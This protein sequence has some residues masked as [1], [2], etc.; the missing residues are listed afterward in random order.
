M[1]TILRRS[2]VKCSEQFQESAIPTGVQRSAFFR[3]FEGVKVWLEVYSTDGYEV[4]FKACMNDLA[5]GLGMMVAKSAPFLSGFPCVCRDS[6]LNAEEADGE[7][8]A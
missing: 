6:A 5:Y 4:D 3:P 8:A 2:I 7:S 1:A